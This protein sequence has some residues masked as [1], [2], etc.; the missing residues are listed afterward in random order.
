[1]NWHKAKEIF[2][3]HGINSHLDQAAWLKANRSAESAIRQFAKR[4]FIYDID[5]LR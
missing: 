4:G 1:M 2:E 3:K 5:R